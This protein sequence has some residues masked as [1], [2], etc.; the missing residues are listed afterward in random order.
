MEASSNPSVADLAE[1]LGGP[2]DRVKSLLAQVRSESGPP[3]ITVA[4]ANAEVQRQNRS[5]WAIAAVVL[6]VAF[7]LLAFFAMLFS[8]TT[9]RTGTPAPPAI[10][11]IPAPEIAPPVETPT[12]TR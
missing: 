5:A 12:P 11:G 1:G 3:A 6:V 8:S 9:V 4:E 7:V 10:E 2:A